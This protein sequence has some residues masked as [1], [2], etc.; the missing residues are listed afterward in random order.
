MPLALVCAIATPLAALFWLSGAV[1]ILAA[2]AAM[3]LTTL[4]VLPVGCALLRA[5][6]APDASPCAAWVL[7]IFAISLALYGLTQWL[8]IRVTIAAAMLATVA[9]GLAWKQRLWRARIDPRELLGVLLCGAVT[10]LWCHHSAAAPA[11][12]ARLGVLPLWVDYMIDGGLI[13]SFGDP[14]AQGAE[15]VELAGFPRPFYHYA[16][17]LLPA[18]FAQPFDLPG[19]PLATSLWLPLGFFTMCA[20]GY[21]FGAALS[22]PAGGVAAVA[23]L[24]LLPDA[25]DYGLR[26]ALFGFGWHVLIRPS[27]AF[28]IGIALVSFVLLQR[29]CAERRPQLL[30]ASLALASGL[31]LFRAQIFVLA[32]PCVLA[33]AAVATKEFR[34]RA[35]LYS[36]AALILLVALYLI[37]DAPRALRPF[38]LT[39]HEQPGIAY[40]GWYHAL[41]QRYGAGIAVPMG[42]LLVFPAFLGLFTLL[43]PLA[44]WLRHRT[45]F[46]AAPLV[47]LGSYAALMALAPIPANGD[48]TEFTQRPFALVYALVSVWTV[49]VLAQRIHFGWLLALSAAA[50]VALWPDHGFTRDGPKVSWGWN[51]YARALTPG[52]EAAAHFLRNEGRPG[53]RFAVASLPRG[54]API[55]QPGWV[56]TD[57][58]IELTALSG[59]SA[60]LARPYLHLASGGERQWVTQERQ[61]ALEAVAR[62]TLA[63]AALARLAALGVRWYV[64][65]GERG[66]VWDPQRQGAVFRDRRVAVYLTTS[67]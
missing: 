32:L 12:L 36:G 6:G 16:S 4:V 54:W 24:T 11:T 66:P 50:V 48:A 44:L 19:L 42:M 55:E 5:A 51:Y 14:L 29:W 35:V 1:S 40:E 45:A 26:N 49:A 62:E 60:Y 22:G 47:L 9:G 67:R 33:V 17:Y 38:L 43:Y 34:R 21:A 18:V 10:L 28:G 27:A 23:A 3:V 13:S 25:G 2:F 39:V 8:E 20:G 65:T 64:V 58:A 37:I 53:D 31:L 61:A 56:P 57:A 46:D 15:S 52:L 30:A 59:M 63:A 7:G 41:L